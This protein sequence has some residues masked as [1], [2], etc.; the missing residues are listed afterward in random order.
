[1][2]GTY[3]GGVGN[4]GFFYVAGVDEA[5]RGALAGPVVAA[6]VVLREDVEIPGL[7]D[8][9]SLT[10]LHRAELCSIILEEAAA[11]GVGIASVG[12][13]DAENVL[14]AALLAMARAVERTEIIPRYVLVD[15]NKKIPTLVPQT[16]IVGGDGKVASIS[17][18]SIVA[19]VRRD[20]MMERLAVAYPRYGFEKHKGYATARHKEALKRYGPT[21]HH[22]YTFRPVRECMY[23]VSS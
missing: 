13:V 23:V 15:G 9:K 4:E 14:N 21:P 7:A 1:M 12:V 19:K 2:V 3:S 18:A 10:A 22:R 20:A 6:A 8:S 17:A 5:G 11:V 16:P